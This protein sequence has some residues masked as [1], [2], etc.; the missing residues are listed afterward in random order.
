VSKFRKIDLSGIRRC[1]IEDRASKVAVELFGA[2]LPSDDDCPT[3]KF[4]DSLPR[5]LKANDFRSLIRRC[6]NA[7]ISKKRIILMSGAHTLKVGLSPL[8]ADFV[9]FYPNVHLATNGAGL[10]HDLEIAYFGATSEDVEENLKHGS[11]GMVKETAELF[12]AAVEIAAGS[13]VGLGEAAGIMMEREKP[14][15]AEY[16]IARIWYG[17][18]CPFTVHIAVG[19]DI[20]C[21]HPEYDGA[22]A[23][24]ASHIDFRLLCNSVSELSDGGVVIN[25]GS[26]VTMPEV[27]LKALAVARNL[28]DSLTGFTT[29]NFDMIR[30]YRPSMNI[31]KRPAVLGAEGFDFAGH[32]EIMIPLLLAAVKEAASKGIGD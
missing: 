29:A 7:V 18:D 30:H 28:D 31:V 19:T 11:F 3:T 17:S 25:I 20:V 23:G 2:P 27:F 14:P 24:R 12:C 6:A 8:F 15:Y 26:A 4:V 32:H 10:I 21:Q 9:R 13:E 22:K 16:S 5:F 1:S